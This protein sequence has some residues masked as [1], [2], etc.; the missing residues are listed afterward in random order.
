MPGILIQIDGFASHSYPNR[1]FREDP[2]SGRGGIYTY[3]EEL[4]FLQRFG[5]GNMPVFITETGWKQEGLSEEEVASFYRFAF[6][7]VWQEPNVIAVTPFLLNGQSSAFSGFSLLR[8]D[9]SPTSMYKTIISLPKVGGEP[10]IA[11]VPKKEEPKLFPPLL[12]NF[13]S[14]GSSLPVIELSQPLSA[15]LKW[16][17]YR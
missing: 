1:D 3:R 2:R 4:T 15:I 6:E 16:F 8:I 5:R 12:K 7:E 14:T 9:G 11:D 10:I 17:F 13:D